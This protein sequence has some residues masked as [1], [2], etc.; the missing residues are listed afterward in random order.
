MKKTDLNLITKLTASA[1]RS[2]IQM[3][4][5]QAVG[6]GGRQRRELLGPG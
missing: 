5:R 3:Q 6:F 4:K 1:G 2:V